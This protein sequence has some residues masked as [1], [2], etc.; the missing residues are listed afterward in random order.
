[1]ALTFPLEKIAPAVPETLQQLIQVQFEQLSMSEQGILRSAS[2]AGD[3]FLSGLSPARWNR[4][5][6][7]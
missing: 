2:V 4:I 6:A 3:R 7:A 5:Q 1:M